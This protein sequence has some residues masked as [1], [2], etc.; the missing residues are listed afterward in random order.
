MVGVDLDPAALRRNRAL[1]LSVCSSLDRLPISDESFDLVTCN[2]VVEHLENPSTAFQELARVLRP[3]GLLIVHTP[4]VLNYAVWGARGLKALLPRR[5]ILTLV[6]WSDTREAEEVF[7]TFYRAN[8]LKKLRHLLGEMGLA[9]E[10]CHML[11]GPQPVCS[12]FAPVALVELLVMRATMLA[13]LRHF[14][15]AI[16]GVYRKSRP[17]DQ[18]RAPERVIL[19]GR[20]DRSKDQKS[21]FSDLFPSSRSLSSGTR[22]RSHADWG[23]DS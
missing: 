18:L 6:R 4:N 16:L 1:S 10:A 12:F 23:R 14:A 7:P 9:E 20:T 5:V 11:V 19:T 15:T 8:S 2:M 21:R 3:N 13:P 22:R 17:V